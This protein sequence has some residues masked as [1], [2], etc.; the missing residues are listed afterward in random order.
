[1]AV[2]MKKIKNLLTIV[3]YV[4]LLAGGIA[5]A[6][7]AGDNSA[8]NMDEKQLDRISLDLKGI[9]IVEFLRILSLKTGWTIVPSKNV[10]GRVTV[11]LNNIRF[12]DALDVVLISQNLAC[13]KKNDIIYVMTEAE[14]KTMYGRDYIENR[15]HLNIKLKYAA[16]ENIFNVITQLKSEIGKV[17]IDEATGMILLI[18][19]PDKLKL[20]SNAIKQLDIP[21]ETIVFDLNYAD[22]EKIKSSLSEIITPNTGKIIIDERVSKVI[23]SDLP[24][25]MAKI[26]QIIK[27]FDEEERQV[28][29]EAEI[30][31]VNLNDTF[32]RGIDWERF[33]GE[34]NLDGL[35]FVSNFPISPAVSSSGKVSI[36][37]V[38]SDDYSMVLEFI[39]RCGD[40]KILSRPRISV[41]N[42]QEAKIMVGKRDA[43]VTQTLSQAEASTVTS[44]N[45]EFIEV[46]VKLSV[47]PT[48]NKEGFV[49]LR[50]KPEV[51]SVSEIVS[52]SIGS[53]IPIVETSEAE[54]MVKVQDG[55]MIMIAGLMKEEKRKENTGIP[56]LSRIPLLGALFS[57]RSI[58]KI[59]TELIIFLTPHLISGASGEKRIEPD[60][61]IPPDI[62]PEDMKRN[63]ILREI[64]KIKPLPETVPQEEGLIAE[65]E[66]QITEDKGI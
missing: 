35:D 15:E 53:R 14:Y 12:Q 3:F 8:E 1:M 27:D 29:I 24:A 6:E 63:I 19:T 47:T 41:V 17:I 46:G 57:S 38:A 9:N 65:F 39:Q 52:T 51:S 25:K 16:P 28:F 58:E 32:N 44:E 22:A 30:L 5:F 26:R 40:L 21:L 42:N 23:V 66:K 36:G 59:K 10:A 61:R 18:D 54:T 56:G 64:N 4:I 11:F 34:H 20:M 45:V 49:I 37:T 7:D 48:I 50:I 55:T 13:E 60:L 43:Y 33:L 31:Q 2:A 62:M